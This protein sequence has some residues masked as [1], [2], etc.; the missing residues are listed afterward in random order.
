MI[1][2]LI[3][4]DEPHVCRELQ[5]ILE[6]DDS[7]QIVAIC[8]SGT[9]TL[10][11]I[12]KLNPDIV[13]LDIA[14]PGF[15]GI[16]LGYYLKKI[17]PQPYLI[18]VTAYDAYAVEAFRV[19]AKGYLLKPFSK[20]DVCEQIKQ[21]KHYL[22]LCVTASSKS[23]TN[24]TR[25]T[26][27]KL[28]V[29]SAGKFKLLDKSDIVFAYADN[30]AVFIRTRNGKYCINRTLTELENEFDPEAFVRC[31]RN[32]LVNISKVKEIIP[33]FKSTYLLVMEDMT[34]IPV[35]RAKAKYIRSLFLI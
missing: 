9:E 16:Q 26:H 33:W 14:M 25:F 30:R 2:V 12:S 15:N 32:Y 27:R 1:K 31:H 23:S 28:A 7:L 21:A 11:Q 29:E 20:E 6:Q 3:A 4:D 22:G 13:L 17:S 8:S 10:E 34:K 19:G 18:F 24:H 35:S 5:Y